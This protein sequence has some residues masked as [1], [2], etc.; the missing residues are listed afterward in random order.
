LLAWP[1]IKKSLWQL[2][3]QSGLS[4]SSVWTAAK[5]SHI[6]PYDIS[7]PPKIK[8]IDHGKSEVL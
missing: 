4:V 1:L 3:K 7:A 2:A 8:P 6:C 5:L